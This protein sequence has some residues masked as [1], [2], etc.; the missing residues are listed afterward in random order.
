AS[1]IALSGGT[2]ISGDRLYELEA[3]RL[4]I[5]KKVLPSYGQAARPVDLFEKSFPEIFALKINRNFG[6]WWLVGYFNWDEAQT[7]RDFELSRLGLSPEKSYLLYEFW[8]QLLLTD[9]VGKVRL[10]FEP[11]SVNLIAV[12]EKRGVPQLL[13]TDRHFTQGGLELENVRWD[14]SQ[15]ILS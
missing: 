9:A 11:S 15:R 14:R 6:Q 8:T 3:A 2:V 13:G 7:V 1:I 5:L 4:E 10:T 12:H